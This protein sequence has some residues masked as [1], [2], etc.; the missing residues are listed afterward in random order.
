V[1]TSLESIFAARTEQLRVAVVGLGY[2]GPNLVR[3]LH[4]VTEARVVASFDLRPE[5]AAQIAAR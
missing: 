5:R 2:W 4:D 3:V 1:T